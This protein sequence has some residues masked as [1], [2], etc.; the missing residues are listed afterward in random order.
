MKLLIDANLSWRLCKLLKY[1]L[2]DC[3][4][5]NRIPLRKPA[6]DSEIW[7]FAKKNNYIILSQDEDFVFLSYR[8]GFPPKVI[9]LRTGNLSVQEIAE[10]LNSKKVEIEKFVSDPDYSLLEIF[11]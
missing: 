9:F 2:S 10:I 11:S 8:F 4:H 3:I 6:K 7:E 5:V 1:N